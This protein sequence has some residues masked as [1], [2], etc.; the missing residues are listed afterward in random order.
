MGPLDLT[1]EK[2]SFTFQRL[3]QTDNLGNFYDG[4]GGPVIINTTSYFYQNTVPISAAMHDRW[5]HSDTGI[6]YVYIDDGI[7]K[8]WVQPY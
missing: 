8:Q 6:E 7:S 2:I 5:F 1:N 3:I 4:L